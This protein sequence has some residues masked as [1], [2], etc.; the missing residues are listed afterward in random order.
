MA[1]TAEPGTEV[2][3]LTV[4]PLTIEAFAPFGDVL[5]VEGRDRLPINLYEGIDVYRADFESARPMEF[6]LTQNKVREFRVLFLERHLELTQM[7]VSLG[8]D[9]FIQVVAKP[10]ARMDNDVPAFDE[11]RAFMVP[12][13]VGTN[14][15][16]GTWHEPPFALVDDQVFLYTS[17]AD[18]TVG[19]G[20]SLDQRK[21]IGELDVD[22][23][24]VTE[25]G[26]YVLRLEMP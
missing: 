21:S 22:K 10:D 15:H 8:G 9:P 3:S 13:N 26:G 20:A 12:G 14:M 16:I 4:E 24:N 11:I 17:H 5:S 19:L 2:R 1:T 25:H 23:R 7:F 18:L 6:L